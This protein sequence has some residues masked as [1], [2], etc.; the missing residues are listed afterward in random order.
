MAPGPKGRKQP[1]LDLSFVLRPPRS[2]LSLLGTVLRTAGAIKDAYDEGRQLAVD[3]RAVI[4]E[5]RDVLRDIGS[6]VGIRVGDVDERSDAGPV[7][8]SPK[9][10][11]ARE[12]RCK[13]CGAPAARTWRG[14]CEK[15]RR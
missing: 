13:E 9:E 10:A 11:R 6:V 7:G 4:E 15:C 8:P 1:P 14:K 5:G 12:R 2:T 3:G